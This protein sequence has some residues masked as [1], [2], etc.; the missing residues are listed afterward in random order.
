MLLPRSASLVL[1]IAMALV[2]LALL[3]APTHAGPRER[4]VTD[5]L[6]WL[7]VSER[8]PRSRLDARDREAIARAER[9]L[10]LFVDGRLERH[11]RRALLAAADERKRTEGYRVIEDRATGARLGVPRAW[12]GRPER[13][14]DGTRW[15]S[16]DGAIALRSFRTPVDLG[17]VE[18]RERAR[19]GTRITYDVGGRG[20]TVLSGYRQGRPFY[21]RAERAGGETR[22]FRVEYDPALRERLDR[23][24][25]AM[26]GDFDPFA[27][28]PR[29]EAEIAAAP[30]FPILPG[31]GP[32]PR[33][34]ALS[35]RSVAVASLPPVER[36]ARAEPDVPARATETP[37]RPTAL[38]DDPIPPLEGPRREVEA[39]APPVPDADEGDVALLDP[40]GTE[41]AVPREIT[42]LL[43][44]EGQSC[45]TLRGPDGTLYALVGE[46]P[47][48]RA[49]TL[50]TIEAV[51]VDGAGRCSAGRTVAVGSF[52]VR[53]PR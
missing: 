2:L 38:D 23:I 36:E 5:A 8:V 46:V 39:D 35:R 16:P 4:A 18:R 47:S 3:A 21:L 13:L 30:R 53:Q 14:R 48:V 37:D 15:A 7:G 42:G 50:V 43:T 6:I 40:E 25:V 27:S 44:D 34:R 29:G 24:V 45:P 28:Q 31:A 20:W 17:T 52:R 11:E 32:E 19:R 51:E 41:R 9:R 22:G 33:R 49:G 1:A 12:M 10:G 26:S